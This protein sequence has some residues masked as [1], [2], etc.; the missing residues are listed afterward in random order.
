ML[1][2][3]NLDY[4]YKQEVIFQDI[5]FS[6]PR[7]AITIILGRSGVGKT[8]LFRLLSGLLLPDQ[9]SLLWQGEPLTQDLVAYM[10]QKE[11][12]LPWRT[13]LK[14]ILL[15]YELGPSHLRTSVPS[16]QL[17]KIIKNFDLDT[18]LDRYPDELSGGQR[19]RVALATQYLSQKPILLLDEPFSSLDLL[20]KE[21][22]Y[23]D[24]EMLAKQENKAV[25]LVTHD[26]RDVLFLGDFVFVIKN[27]KCIPVSLQRVS[28]NDHHVLNS[29]KDLLSTT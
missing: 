26:F 7:G 8:T 14:N 23:K 11:A 24:I 18:I 9:G 29:L 16:Y 17:Q 2:V 12:L 10:Q 5:S 1:Q 6:A 3:S 27:H 13:A 15:P 28:S 21:Q 4:S 22:L 19:Q 25:I 20:L